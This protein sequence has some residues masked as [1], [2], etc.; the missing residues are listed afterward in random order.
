[1]SVNTLADNWSKR[2]NEM[3]E[4]GDMVPIGN[5]KWMSKSAWHN[6]INKANENILSTGISFVGELDHPAN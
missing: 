5:G 3:K 1:M 6:A 4:S 2:F